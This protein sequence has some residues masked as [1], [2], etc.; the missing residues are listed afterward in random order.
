MIA[1]VSLIGLNAAIG[2]EMTNGFTAPG[3]DSQLLNGFSLSRVGEK[4][5]RRCFNDDLSV[6]SALRGEAV[7]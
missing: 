6:N 1:S 3:F 7:C 5:A 2:G 4:G